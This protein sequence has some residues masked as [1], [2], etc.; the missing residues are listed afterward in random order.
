MY[1]PSNRPNP[2]DVLAGWHQTASFYRENPQRRFFVRPPIGNECGGPALVA[3]RTVWKDPPAYEQIHIISSPLLAD[4]Y[5][6][7]VGEIAGYEMY[8]SAGWF[9]PHLYRSDLVTIDPVQLIGIKA[10]M[11]EYPPAA[12]ILDH[13]QHEQDYW[14]HK[15]W[16]ERPEHER[17]AIEAANQNLWGVA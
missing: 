3:A 11:G 2:A 5:R 16:L 1:P 17:R 7:D 10:Y 14:R 12:F 8:K 15:A 9:W 6:R 13:I 4:F